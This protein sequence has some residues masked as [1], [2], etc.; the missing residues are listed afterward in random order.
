MKIRTDFVTN[1]SSS[2]F[3]FGTLNVNSGVS[4]QDLVN[5]FKEMTVKIDNIINYLDTIFDVSIIRKLNKEWYNDGYN[6]N[7][8]LLI[9]AI[10]LREEIESTDKFKNTFK[11][12]IKKNNLDIE[13]PYLSIE[14]SILDYYFEKS[15]EESLSKML[16]TIVDIIDD[17]KTNNVDISKYDGAILDKGINPIIANHEALQENTTQEINKFGEYGIQYWD[18][19]VPTVLTCIFAYYSSGYDI[20]Y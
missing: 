20:H 4:K 1:S 10:N 13:I 8:A 9:E 17:F 14:A 6:R 12:E 7:D 5:K 3:I 2:C 11:N 18:T 19:S 15:E 16:D